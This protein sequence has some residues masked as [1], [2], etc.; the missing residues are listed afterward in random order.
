MRKMTP[1]ISGFFTL[2]SFFWFTWAIAEN[3]GVAGSIYGAYAC[4]ILAGIALVLNLVLGFLELRES[5]AA[6][7]S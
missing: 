1:N 3:S 2:V 7:A 4:I 6:R 5:N